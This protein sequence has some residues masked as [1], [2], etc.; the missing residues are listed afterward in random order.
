MGSKEQLHKRNRHRSPYDFV[1]LVNHNPDLKQYIINTDYNHKSIDFTNPAAVLQLNRALIFSHYDIYF[2]DLPESFLCPAVPGR[3]DYIHYAADLFESHYNDLHCLDIGTGANC[4]YPI[5]AV[6]DYQWNMICSEIDP[7]AFKV[8]E[9]IIGFNPMLKKKV[10]LRLQ[11]QK[12]AILHG[13]IM[14]HDR[15]DLVIC[16]PPFYK[17]EAQA[18]KKTERKNTNLNLKK[19]T[20]TRNFSGRSHE[21]V[22]PG[23]ELDFIIKMIIES[24]D[25]RDQVTWFTSLVSDKNNIVPLQ[26]S[27]RLNQVG[28]I[29]I[30]PMSQGHKASRILAWKF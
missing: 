11:K 25:Y 1:Q 5:I 16:N 3:A 9:A 10:K 24:N 13:I 8:A 30:I 17:S 6:K 21:L 4:I 15:L 2:W 18:L 7:E 14:D 28:D 27:L 22:Y 19:E 12:D 20:T 23:G 26:K 29:K